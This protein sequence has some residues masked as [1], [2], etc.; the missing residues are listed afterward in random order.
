MSYSGD[1]QAMFGQPLQA[2]PSS[3]HLAVRWNH[4]GQ[5]QDCCRQALRGMVAGDRGK[6]YIQ[7]SVLQVNCIKEINS[8]PFGNNDSRILILICHPLRVQNLPKRL[9]GQDSVFELALFKF[10][11]ALPSINHP[12]RKKMTWSVCIAGIAQGRK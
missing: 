8:E 11:L 5:Q 6:V 12:L 1:T 4:G 10:D 3:P 7:D 9:T 2:A